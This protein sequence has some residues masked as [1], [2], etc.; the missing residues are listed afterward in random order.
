MLDDYESEVAP[1]IGETLTCTHDNGESESH[2]VVDVRHL[3]VDT[4]N[5]STKLIGLMVLVE[6]LPNQDMWKPL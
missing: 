6:A 5:R 3:R 2:K 1:R 4:L